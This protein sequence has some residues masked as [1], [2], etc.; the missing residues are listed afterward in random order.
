METNPILRDT[1]LEVVQNQIDAD[2]PPETAKTLLRL[3]DQGFSEED[4]MKY[5]G[6]AVCVEIW[7]SLH[8]QNE[9]NLQRY[10]RNLH[11]LPEEPKE[12]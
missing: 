3:K 4:A 9:F 6:Q 5:I 12:K 1:I 10:I 11:R 7:D 2:D 8:N